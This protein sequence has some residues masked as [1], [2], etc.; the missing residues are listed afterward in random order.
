MTTIQFL[1]AAGTVSGSKY[2]VDT[3][4]TRFFVDY[5]MFQGPKRLRLLNWQKPS[6][7]PA[8]VGHVLLTHAH[9]DHSGMLPALVRDGFAGKIWTTQVTAELS[10]IS[11]LDAAHL[12][13]EDARF[14]NKMKFSKHEPA[15]PLFTTADAEKAITHLKGVDYG[16]R[17]AIS[18]D[19]EVR[20][21]DAGHIL[22]SAIVEVSGRGQAPT[23]IVFSG[24]L[25]RYDA[26]ILRDPEPVEDAD[27]LLIESTY[28]NRT[29]PPEEPVDELASIIDE[30]ARRGGMLIIPA[31]A[32]GRTQTLLYLLR[33][34]KLKGAIPDLPIF[35]D[36]P[37]ARRVTDVFC[38]HIEE[39]DEDAQ[40][41]YRKTGVCPVLS[42]KLTFTHTKEESQKINDLRYPAIIVSASGMATGGRVLHHLRY[43]LPDPRNT[44]LFV[45]YQA[46]GTRGQLLRDGA[47][48]IKM[49]G[50]NVPV[51][52]QIRNIEAF[53]GHADAT[54]ILRW[55]GR[56][57]KPPK[58]TF[59]V[60]GEPESSKA[61]AKLIGERLGWK[62]HIPEHQETCVLR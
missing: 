37:M 21:R 58:T 42:D 18:A 35:V 36:S 25:G 48:S 10:K 9:L 7:D 23:R 46:M 41:V 56:F 33:D 61:L 2:L 40:A 12:Q 22:G 5:G 17:Q 53:S 27:Y 43:R 31:F 57:R 3:G 6:F 60:H 44:V 4:E 51:R 50:E 29:H 49:H 19:T 34:M 24:D 32:V 11:L 26:L 8:S 28:G 13:E 14:A 1:G 30:T 45:G 55:L 52:A 16:V 39:F 15:L 54:E 38:K 20:F 59:V 47:K 62:T